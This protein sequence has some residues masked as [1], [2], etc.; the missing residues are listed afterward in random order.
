MPDI[1]RMRNEKGVNPAKIVVVCIIVLA[2]LIVVANSFTSVDAGHTGVITT[3]GKVDDVVLTEGLHF[4]VPFAQNIV[5]MDNR[6]LKAEVSCSSA[7]KDLQTVSSTIA[8]NYR[9]ENLSSA[10]LYKKVGLDYENKIVNPSIQETVKAVTAQFTAE[11]LITNR[12]NVGNLMQEALEEKINSFGLSIEL[13]NII[14]FEFSEEFN[15][16]I[17]AKQTAQQNALKAEQ[18]LAR[19]K[20]EAEQKIEQARAEAEAYKLKSLQITESMIIMEYINKWNGELPT[21]ITDGT[22]ILDLSSMVGKIKP[23]TEIAD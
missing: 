13:F 6:V 8:L 15:N 4:K 1:I 20:V 11:E 5:K 12:Q 14:T 3:F 21:V 17:E 9:V 22:N 18:D 16:A 23:S 2:L 10:D 19:I 7:S